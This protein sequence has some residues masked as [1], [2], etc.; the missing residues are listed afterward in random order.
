MQ[1]LER[2]ECTH[3]VLDFKSCSSLFNELASQR[4]Y[5]SNSSLGSPRT[6][7]SLD[8]FSRS[9]M[10]A[11]PS[12]LCHGQGSLDTAVRQARVGGSTLFNTNVRRLISNDSYVLCRVADGTLYNVE[13][14]IKTCSPS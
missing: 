12:F 1:K 11:R 6:K 2:L 10:L 9:C 4:C 8:S 7:S 5:F 14:N 3:N 13:M